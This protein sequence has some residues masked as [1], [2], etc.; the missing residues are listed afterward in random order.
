MP[1]QATD[2]RSRIVD[3]AARLV[4]EQSFARTSLADIARES[5]VPLGNLYYYFKTKDAIGEAL[6][7]KMW[8]AHDATRTTWDA[9]LEP[10]ERI[11]AFIQATIDRRET[12]ARYGCSFGTLCAELHKE[13]GP[14]A[15]RAV[16]LFD[17]FLKWLE[18]Q[19]R[20]LG[21]GAESRDLAFHLV[22]ALQGASLLANTFHNTRQIAREC[23]RLKEWVR[24][25]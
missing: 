7:E 3:T 5:G 14:L 24:S 1:A 23:N 9:D 21:K 6:I 20:L 25:L 18:A 2:K 13:P 17:G 12:V 11:E 10:R 22:S 19:F 8:A 16:T 4:H 15:E